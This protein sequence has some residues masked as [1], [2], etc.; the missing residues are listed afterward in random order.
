MNNNTFVI[1]SSS[2]SSSSSSSNKLSEIDLANGYTQIAPNVYKFID[3]NANDNID[4][5]TVCE[6]QLTK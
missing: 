3:I 4:S 2:L 5:I 6:K 1:P